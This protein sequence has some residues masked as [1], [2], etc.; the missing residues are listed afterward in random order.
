[1]KQSHTR[2]FGAFGRMQPTR[3]SSVFDRNS[4]LW[5]K[6]LVVLSEVLRRKC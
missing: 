5:E 4:I 2:R 6:V 3:F 1:M